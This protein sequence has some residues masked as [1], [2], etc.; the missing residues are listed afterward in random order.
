MAE[1]E[2]GGILAARLRRV[3]GLI[4]DRACEPRFTVETVAVELAVSTRTIQLILERTGST[5]SEHVSEQ[6]LHRAWRLLSDPQSHLSIAQVAF[7]SGF[8]DLS[9]FYRSFRRRFGETP[10]SARASSSRGLH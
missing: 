5:F 2:A 3:L 10:A 8:N 7:E 1:A 4:A 9:Y 6:R